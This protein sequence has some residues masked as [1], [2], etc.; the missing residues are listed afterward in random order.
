[1]T[2]VGSIRGQIRIDAQQALAEYAAVRASNLKTRESLLASSAAFAKVGVAAL[3]VAAPIAIL[4]AAAV[5]EAANFQK[6][7]DYFGAVTGATQ[8]DM[9]AVAKTALEMS[10]TTIYSASQMADA[11]VEFGKAGIATKDIIGG[12][13][14]ATTDLAQAA[15]ISVGDAAYVIAATMATFKIQAKDTQ[16]ISDQLAGAAN[17]SIIDVSDV[18]TSLKYAGSIAATTGISFDSLIT[19]I[20]LL[21]KAGV[22]GSQAGTSLRQIMV[23][24]VHPTKAAEEVMKELGLTTKD[25]SN[26][27]ID[28]KGHIKSLSDIFQILQDHMHGLTQAQQLSAEK[29]LFNSRALSAVA[30]LT[31]EGAAGFAAMSAAV[32]N[33]TAADVAHKR[34]DN[35]A[36]DIKRLKN[37]I[38]TMLIE[39]GGPLQDVLRHIVQWLT[40]AAQWFGNLSPEMQKGILYGGLIVGTFFSIVGVLSLMISM[41]MKAVMVYRDLK[42]AFIIVRGAVLAFSTAFRTAALALVTN[43]IFLMVT[44]IVALVAGFIYCWKHFKAFR[45]FFKDAWR[46]IKAWFFDAWH[47]ID[48]TMH[49][50]ADVAVVAWNGFYKYFVHP[51]MTAWRDVVGA[52][53]A[54]YDWISRVI[55]DILSFLLRHWKA[56]IAIVLGPIGL[57]IDAITTHWTW[58]KNTTISVFNFILSVLKFIWNVIYTV[59][60]TAIKIIVK[61]ITTTWD[62]IRTSTVAVWN[63]ILTFFRFIWNLIYQFFAI[64][65]KALISIFTWVWDQIGGPL[66][67]F[68]NGIYGFFKTVFTAIYRVVSSVLTSIW[69]VFYNILSK[70]GK[71]VGSAV[72]AIW[73]TISGAAK[74]IFNAGA[75]IAVQIWNGIYS[76]LKDI[77]SIGKWLVT[78]IWNG[79][80]NMAQWLWDHVSK[81]ISTIWHSIL[82]WFGISS[83]SKKA[84]AAGEFIVMGLANGI[85]SK[86]ALAVSA[87]AD[88]NNSLQNAGNLVVGGKF[89]AQTATSRALS[90][91][92]APKANA[93]GTYGQTGGTGN[94]GPHL[95]IENLNMVNPARETT[96]QSIP[97][98]VRRV[99]FIASGPGR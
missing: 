81:F 1:M 78:G 17:A 40:K 51:I 37:S 41:I 28:Q 2:T 99:N 55:G 20:S 82:D 32:G 9:K 76:I 3:A 92:N 43:P 73:N 25:G 84:H 21:G 72:S 96:S 79:I 69:N 6:K 48:K 30:I 97:R 35:L 24:L 26:L 4:F 60:S 54:A 75:N 95:V 49:D 68:W 88:L 52:F 90:S 39:A 10:K 71:F 15:D 53:K 91:M 58:I 13:A 89:S 63:A 87:M 7:I 74:Y 16:H 86:K 64:Q 80:S 85:M 18:A 77:G 62:V 47:W 38:Q 67:A 56:V 34:L 42:A 5:S 8:E 50:I 44:A 94:T 31:R 98:A 66:I 22:K 70:V 14:K 83:P 57:T 33:V 61:V 23:S 12:V 27:F 11:F 46:D 93:Y 65:V 45:D 59:I 19:A 29:T 36:G